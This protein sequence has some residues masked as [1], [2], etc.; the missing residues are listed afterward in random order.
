MLLLLVSLAAL[1][2][3][4]VLFRVAGHASVRRAGRMAELLVLV[5]VGALVVLHILPDAVARVGWIVMLPLVLGLL[6]PTLT[7]RWLRSSA[8]RAHLLVRIIVVTGLAVHA[9]A[10]GLG[11]AVPGSHEDVALHALPLAIALHRIPVGLVIWWLV[12]PAYGVK[13]AV[14]VL[15]LIAIATVAGYAAAGVVTGVVRGPLLALFQAWVAGSLL[16]VAVHPLDGH[17]GGHAHT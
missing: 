7:E 10:D 8:H 13:L 5:A 6:G 1:A 2:L 9:F 15:A 11:L 4:P 12:K 14:G 17:G 3:G 16:H